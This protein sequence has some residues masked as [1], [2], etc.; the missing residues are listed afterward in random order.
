MNLDYQKQELTCHTKLDDSVGKEIKKTEEKEPLK[1]QLV[2]FIECVKNG[3]QPL[4]SGHEGK[5][6]L[7]IA[8]KI[9]E[10]VN[11]N[12]KI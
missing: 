2:S 10:L 7:K 11:H 4:V 8:L 3:T 6:A 12:L 1:E 5:E 9:S